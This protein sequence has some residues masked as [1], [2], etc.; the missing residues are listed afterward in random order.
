VPAVIITTSLHEIVKSIVACKYSGKPKQNR[1]SFNPFI[2]MDPLGTIFLLF[3]G[4]GWSKPTSFAPNEFTNPKKTFMLIFFI[5]FI[6]HLIIA[7]TMFYIY[8]LL[9]FNQLISLVT[10]SRFDIY[11]LILNSLQMIIIYNLTFA[12]MSILPIHPFNGINL[13]AAYSPITATKIASIEGFF[14]AIIILII[15]FGFAEIIIYSPVTNFL[16][17]LSLYFRSS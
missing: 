12:T 14:Q 4:F 9:I 3:F 16:H 5:P 15:V 17:Q 7:F 8:E 10:A 1:I 11:G 6:T 13:L 2:Y